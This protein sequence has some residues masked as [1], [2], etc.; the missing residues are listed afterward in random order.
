MVPDFPDEATFLKPDERLRALRRL[1]QDQ[2]A[3]GSHEK[4]NSIYV[5][6]ALTDWKTYLYMAIYGGCAGSLYAFSLFL[7]T[8]IQELGIVHTPT[9][10]NL[11][12]VPSYMAAVVLTIAIGWYADKTQYRGFC[13]LAMSLLA[14]VGFV[15]MLGSNR[16]GIKYAGTYLAALGIYPTIPNTIT[17]VSNNTEGVFKRGIVLGMVIG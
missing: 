12:S 17:W 7:P 6:Q 4:M 5:W 13:N 14:I 1:R 2:Q 16:S 15:M 11:M 10:V 9:Q 8:I 3:S